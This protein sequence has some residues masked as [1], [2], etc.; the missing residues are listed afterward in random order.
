MTRDSFKNSFAD[1][2]CVVKELDH[3]HDTKF[4]FECYDLGHLYNPRV[5]DRTE[6]WLEPP[7]FVQM[8]FG[9]LGGVGADHDNLM[10]MHAIAEKLFDISYE[11]LV[12]AAGRHQ[13]WDQPT[14]A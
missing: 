9:V 5:A 11:G 7:Y 6:G 1:L 4:E 13:L 10:P 12:L 8:V 2:E 14:Q 3:G